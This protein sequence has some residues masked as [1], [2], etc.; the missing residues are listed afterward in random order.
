MHRSLPQLELGVPLKD[1]ASNRLIGGQLELSLVV[2]AAHGVLIQ[3]L[4]QDAGGV[5]V[6]ENFTR[7]DEVILSRLVQ[8]VHEPHR[9]VEVLAR[10][11]A[12]QPP[13][14]VGEMESLVRV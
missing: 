9:L 6:G 14:L 8:E 12:A 10:S 7:L 1:R 5:R 13:D 3:D 4:A 11:G 2:D